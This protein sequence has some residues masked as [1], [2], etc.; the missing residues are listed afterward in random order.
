MATKSNA[1]IQN[2]K[3]G[4]KK[5]EQID[6]RSNLYPG[7]DLSIAASALQKSI[8]RNEPELALKMAFLLM[9]KFP[10]YCIKR[11]Q[12][13]ASEDIGNADPQAAV[14]A[15]AIGQAWQSCKLRS[16]E[17]TG[18]VMIAHLVLYL[19]RASKNRE[20]DHAT[21]YI[22]EWLKSKESIEIPDWVYDKHTLK[23]KQL[24]RKMKH[25]MEVGAKLV[26]EKGS[27]IYRERMIDYLKSINKY[28]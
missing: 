15:A 4:N 26:N 14:L 19:C 1:L 7:I 18:L 27:D 20:A 16:P 3:P 9:S 22:E 12:V 8:R 21:I 23:G 24:K 5:V 6:Y 13:C 28:D 2:S 25:F 10:Y 17:F 11:L